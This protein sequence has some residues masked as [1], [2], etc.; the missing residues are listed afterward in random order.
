MFTVSPNKSYAN[1][2]LPI[3]PATTKLAGILG[4][5]IRSRLEADPSLVRIADTSLS[6]LRVAQS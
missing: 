2:C 1:F 5:R 3:P 4:H 6:V